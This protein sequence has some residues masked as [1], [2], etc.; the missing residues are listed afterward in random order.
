MDVCP[1][2]VMS[3]LGP[4][5][6]SGFGVVCFYMPLLVDFDSEFVLSIVLNLAMAVTLA[7]THSR[8]SQQASLSVHS[9]RL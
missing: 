9:G 1:L 4:E 3:Y 7:P 2:L 6:G 5:V 8:W